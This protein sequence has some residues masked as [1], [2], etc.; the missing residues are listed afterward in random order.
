MTP[1]FV[2]TLAVIAAAALVIWNFVLPIAAHLKAV[3]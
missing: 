3:L 1:R 2:V